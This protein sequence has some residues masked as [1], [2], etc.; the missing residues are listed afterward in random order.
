MKHQ[1]KKYRIQLI[2]LLA[3]ASAGFLYW[4]FV[5][6]Q[7]GTCM[8]TVWYYSS[9]WGAAAGY[10]TGDFI[11]DFVKKRKRENEQ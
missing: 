9:L 6:C 1:I 3:G 4:R 2:F 10:L 11:N 8:I 5:G 7:S